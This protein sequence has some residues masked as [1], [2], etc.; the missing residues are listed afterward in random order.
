MD[1]SKLE[2]IGNIQLFHILRYVNE[3][4]E[5]N[6]FSFDDIESD[7]F[8]HNCDLACKIMGIN[9]VQFIDYNFILSILIINKNYDFNSKKPTG[10]IE[11]PTPNLYSFDIDEYRREYVRISYK[12]E[13]TS[14][15]VELIQPTITSMENDSDFDYYDG[16][17][18]DRDYYDGETTDTKFDKSSIRKLK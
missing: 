13:I 14:Y 11:K 9:D 17:E 1:N 5:Y 3:H 2:N 6:Q 18:S 8:K 7:K 10:V 12:H 15:L 16:V 4:H